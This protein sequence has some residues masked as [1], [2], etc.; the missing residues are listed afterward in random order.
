V[1]IIG[2]SDIR[3]KKR[4]IVILILAAICFCVGF[5]TVVLGEN[6][7][8][9]P[10]PSVLQ[11]FPEGGFSSW[12]DP[13]R[14]QQTTVLIVGVDR[15]DNPDPGLQA[16]WLL[17]MEPPNNS[18]VLSGV[19][20]NLDLVSGA[21]VT[22]QSFFGLTPEGAVAPPFLEAL[23]R[24]LRVEIHHVVALDRTAFATLIDFAGG[25]PIEAD[26][27]FPVGSQVLTGEQVLAL[28]TVFEGDPIGSTR[29]QASVLEGMVPQVA[30]MGA[31]PELQAILALEGTHA[32]LSTSTTQFAVLL[33]HLL[34]LNPEKV[35]IQVI[36]EPI[37]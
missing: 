12:F 33:S 24:A 13:N 14:S 8:A 32:A 4:P 18:V 22:L 7:N 29:L 31:N 17:T 28:Q 1:Q 5:A 15:M 19:P 3:M 23:E 2:G 30:K 20:S 21:N 37:P 27:G 35:E 10:I 6:T 25:L 11:L 34:P 36:L 16:I 26:L 9:S